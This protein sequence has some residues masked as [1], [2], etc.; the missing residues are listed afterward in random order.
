MS[1][2]GYPATES[3]ILKVSTTGNTAVL[4]IQTPNQHRMRQIG[5]D[6]LQKMFITKVNITN[7]IN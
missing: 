3:D 2:G 1:I 7:V 5:F 4:D 6:R